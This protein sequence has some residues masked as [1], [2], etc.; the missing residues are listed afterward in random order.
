VQKATVICNALAA[1]V[2]VIATIYAQVA[3][4]E[5]LSLTTRVPMALG[6]LILVGVQTAGWYQSQ[7]GQDPS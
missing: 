4:A 6:G 7:R 3:F 2:L 5:V 1:I